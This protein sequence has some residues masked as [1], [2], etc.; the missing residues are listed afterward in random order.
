MFRL[1]H[2]LGRKKKSIGPHATVEGSPALALSIRCAR[3]WRLDAR[4]H[5]R[6]PALGRKDTPA[7]VIVAKENERHGKLVRRALNPHKSV[8]LVATMAE[9]RNA[10]AFRGSNPFIHKDAQ[11]CSRN[12][13]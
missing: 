4:I 10:Y 12:V 6:T 11:R 8:L 9:L 5:G 2:P 1:A 13:H 7:A 3:D